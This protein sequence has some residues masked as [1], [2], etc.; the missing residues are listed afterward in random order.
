MQVI[1]LKQN[2]IFIKISTK[3]LD[4]LDLFLEKKALML[5]EQIKLIK[6]IV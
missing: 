5:L 4:F 6:Y 2:K 1:I 3:Y